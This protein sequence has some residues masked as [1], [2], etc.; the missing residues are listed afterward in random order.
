MIVLCCSNENPTWIYILQDFKVFIFSFLVCLISLNCLPRF[1]SYRQRRST[2]L[3]VSKSSCYQNMNMLKNENF[4]I[5][6]CTSSHFKVQIFFSFS[7]PFLSCT[8]T[9]MIDYLYT[10]SWSMV[11]FCLNGFIFI[12]LFQYMWRR[13]RHHIPG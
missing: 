2:I 4:E 1:L 5:A 9:Y 7:L 6:F 11:L 8:T 13:G 10:F 3:K 12:H